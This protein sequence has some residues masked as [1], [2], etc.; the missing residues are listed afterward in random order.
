MHESMMTWNE[1]KK[2]DGDIQFPPSASI[3]LHHKSE[4]LL[5]SMASNE[6]TSETNQ[7]YESFN[8]INEKLSEENKTLRILLKDFEERKTAEENLSEQLFYSN[9]VNKTLEERILDLTSKLQEKDNK[10]DLLKTENDNFKKLTSQLKQEIENYKNKQELD[11][12]HLETKNRLL[13]EAL[14]KRNEDV[15]ALENGNED[16]INLLEKWDDKIQKL[17]ED[18]QVERI[19]IEKYEHVLKDSGKESFKIDAE[20]LDSRINFL[21]ATLEEYR[22]MLEEDS[23]FQMDKMNSEN[24]LI[25]LDKL[26]EKNLITPSRRNTKSMSWGIGGENEKTVNTGTL[27]SEI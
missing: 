11:L 3:N 16:L 4:W 23:D 15:K 17:D 18:L 6:I 12:N 22:K 26:E 20:S 7:N 19:K 5:S 8:G 1:A 27:S 10:I 24:S 21:V 9:K 25:D 14:N 2:S 13:T